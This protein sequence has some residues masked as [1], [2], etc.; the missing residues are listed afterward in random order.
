MR[1]HEEETMFRQGD[2]LFVR[3]NSVPADAEIVRDGVIARGET[4]GHAHRLQLGR[5]RALMLLAGIAFIRARY[6]ATI[7]HEEH[8]AVTLP[9][10]NYKVTRQREYRPQGWETVAD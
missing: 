6:R 9:P 4:S 5:G 2:L 10:G 3:C 1:H 7:T 8:G